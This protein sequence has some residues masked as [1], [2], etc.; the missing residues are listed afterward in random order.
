MEAEGGFAAWKEE[1][2]EFLEIVTFAIDFVGYA[3]LIFTVL[4]F[5]FRYVGFELHRARGHEC[6]KQYQDLRIE[7]L[8]HVILA[9]DFMV[10]S[11]VIHS[12]LVQTRDS[13]ITLGVF[14][15]IRSLLAFFL[16]LDL[17]E[18]REELIEEDS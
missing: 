11:D 18:V 17:R 15:L 9:I 4:K 5:V 16:G 7:F 8:S 6:G 13:L 10:V 3:I 12:G 2:F 1:F 14:V